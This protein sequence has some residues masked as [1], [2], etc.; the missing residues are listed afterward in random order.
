VF[1]FVSSLLILASAVAAT[2]W[3]DFPWLQVHAHI[4]NALRS[5]QVHHRPQAKSEIENSGRSDEAFCYTLE[6]NE[7][8]R[9]GM[10]RGGSAQWPLQCN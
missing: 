6:R 3:M 8:G 1:R 9:R 2:F 10:K 4:L 5:V 7:E